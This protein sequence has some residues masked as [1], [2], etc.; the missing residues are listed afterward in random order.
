MLL[1]SP[2]VPS[3]HLAVHPLGPS[4][5][6]LCDLAL[7]DLKGQ[8]APLFPY[9]FSWSWLCILANAIVFSI[10][11]S[12][13]DLGCSFGLAS[14][15]LPALGLWPWP[16]LKSACLNPVPARLCLWVCSFGTAFGRQL[17]P[18]ETTSRLVIRESPAVKTR[19]LRPRGYL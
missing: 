10:V 4:A 8:C 19:G 17:L 16:C 3:L 14:C 15:L 11:I 2:I 18:W 7:L 12:G 6:A 9:D 1:C 13:I 5:A